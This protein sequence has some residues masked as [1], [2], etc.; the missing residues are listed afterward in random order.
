LNPEGTEIVVRPG[1]EKDLYFV[2]RP[3]GFHFSA[4]ITA[5]QE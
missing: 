5:G 2:P 3:A 4:P 1:E